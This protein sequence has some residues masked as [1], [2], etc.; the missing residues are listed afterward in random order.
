MCILWHFKHF[1]QTFQNERHINRKISGLGHNWN[2]RNIKV[3][4]IAGKFS[5]EWTRNIDILRCPLWYYHHKM[6]HTCF[7]VYFGFTRH[8][9]RKK[10]KDDDS[11]SCSI[12]AVYLHKWIKNFNPD[13]PNPN[14]T[15]VSFKYSPYTYVHCTYLQVH[16][17]LYGVYCV[18]LQTLYSRSNWS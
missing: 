11:F 6:N 15:R 12:K 10:K 16:I 4:M 3:K 9:V 5:T 2:K 14:N 1:S 8:S 18:E 7:F 17:I 13:G